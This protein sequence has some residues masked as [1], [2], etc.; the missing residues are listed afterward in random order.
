[1][2]L[3]NFTSI[4]III[5]GS[6]LM[7]TSCQ[8][9]QTLQK[10]TSYSFNGTEGGGITLETASRWIDN[11]AAKNPSMSKAH[12]FD[13]SEIKRILSTKGAIGIRIYYSINDS[14]KPELLM[15]GTDGNGNDLIETYGLKGAASMTALTGKNNDVFS[16]KQSG[17]LSTDVAR[18]WVSNYVNQN[19]FG[20]RAH[21]FGHEIINQILAEKNC[22][23]IRIYYALNDAGVPQL[24]LVGA[25]GTGE[26]ILPEQGL[27]AKVADDPT[28]PAT[29]ADMSFPC[30]TYCST[31]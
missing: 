5:T 28:A 31:L 27:N 9:S 21:F 30:P 11:F 6:V 16:A 2:K 12:Y 18:Q 22:V 26:N 3:K 23:G 10:N 8:E 25:T 1:M 15:T 19:P 13:Q 7:T 20:T 4:I 14:N 24:L 17:A 29:V